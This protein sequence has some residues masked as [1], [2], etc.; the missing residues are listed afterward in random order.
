MQFLSMGC[1][2]GGVTCGIY[3]KRA[4][5][6]VFVAVVAVTSI[7]VELLIIQSY[8]PKSEGNIFEPLVGIKVWLYSILKID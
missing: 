7:C 3:R 5:V 8:S 4:F 2:L 1:V 6:D